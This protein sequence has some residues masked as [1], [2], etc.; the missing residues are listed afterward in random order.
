MNFFRPLIMAVTSK[1]HTQDVKLVIQYQTRLAHNCNCSYWKTVLPIFRNRVPSFTLSFSSFLLQ[2]SRFA[3]QQSL[4]KNKPTNK[5]LV[6]E[7]L[8]PRFFEIILP[9]KANFQA[10]CSAGRNRHNS[11]VNPKNRQ[12]EINLTNCLNVIIL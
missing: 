4:A 12:P 5:S 3:I 11:S 10:D 9:A 8:Q 7:L 1:K 2:R 6:G